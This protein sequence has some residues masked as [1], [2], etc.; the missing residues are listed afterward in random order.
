VRMGDPIRELR[1]DTPARAGKGSTSARTGPSSRRH[2]RSRGEG[3]P[4]R[5]VTAPGWETPPLARGR[6]L[7]QQVAEPGKTPPLARGRAAR[8]R[9]SSVCRETPPLARGRARITTDEPVALE[10]P[11]LARGRA[12]HT[13]RVDA[14]A[15]DTPARAG[16]GDG[17]Q[18]AQPDD[19]RH[20][21]SRGEGRA[22]TATR[23]RTGETPPLA[24]GR[25]CRG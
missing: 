14:E 6:A 3:P 8:V 25:G 11:P 19:R 23:G 13:P 4:P 15:G 22:R 1:G 9:A 17:E 18:F 5:S 24:R 16:K 21:R 7:G 2:P 20:P 10:T 12:A